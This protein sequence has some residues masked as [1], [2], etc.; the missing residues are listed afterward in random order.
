MKGAPHDIS[1]PAARLLN[2]MGAARPITLGLGLYEDTK[3]A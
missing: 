3:S 2:E 1:F